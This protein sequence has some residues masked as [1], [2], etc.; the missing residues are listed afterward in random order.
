M[1]LTSPLPF[2]LTRAL[3][4]DGERR[5]YLVDPRGLED[6]YSSLYITS[7]LRGAG[8]S[9]ASHEQALA[10]I[11]VLC[12]FC[13]E[14]DI[15][16]LSRFKAGQYLATNECIALA[17][18][19]QNS[20]GAEYKQHQ[21]VVALGKVRR[22]YTYAMPAV[23]RDTRHK[24]L[25]HIAEFVNWLGKYL[26]TGASRE[27][28]RQI[29][30]M[31]DEILRRRPAAGSARDDF[32]VQ[33][34]TP[35]DNERLNQL[36]AP[37]TSGNPFTEVVQLRNLLVIEILRQTGVRIGEAL[38]LKVR[39][40]DHVK[41]EMTVRRRHD[42]IEDPRIDQPLVKTD[43]RVIPLSLFLTD[44][45]VQYVALRRFVP[46]AKKHQYL[47]VTHKAGP[48]QGQPM[49]QSAIDS[50][51][52][53]IAAADEHLS[54]L[55]AHKFRHFFSSELAGEQLTQGTDPNS[56]ELHRR[57]RNYIAGRKAHSEVDSTYTEYDTK[58][59]ARKAMLAVQEKMAPATTA[60]S[61]T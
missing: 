23:A 17:D 26:L 30:E 58:R 49:T 1:S 13:L 4:A 46:G 32:D 54:H 16:L 40:I 39:D 15:D 48:S 56:R 50:M 35:Q 31:R 3:H 20:F 45:V 38:N 18:F 47:L 43:G 42:A 10:S 21:K 44:L 24:R 59:Q 14:R 36:I 27:R 19:A 51:F 12:G 29:E 60:R 57:T 37:G 6:D 22:G 55:T 2:R 11:N 5:V 7:S 53:T 9:V 28:V 8:L 33:H 52:E 25:T 41:R 61:R 34:F